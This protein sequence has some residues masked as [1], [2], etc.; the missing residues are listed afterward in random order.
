MTTVDDIGQ[1]HWTD[2]TVGTWDANA[3]YG[4]SAAAKDERSRRRL[5]V[6]ELL[7]LRRTTTQ[8][9]QAVIAAGFD[10]PSRSTI[11]NDVAA[12]RAQ[13]ARNA[14]AFYG[15]MVEAETA[16]LDDLENLLWSKL[17]GGAEIDGSILNGMLRLMERRAKLHGLDK[18]TRVETTVQVTEAAQQLRRRLDDLL[19]ITPGPLA[20]DVASTVLLPS[21]LPPTERDHSA[22]LAAMAE[23]A[24]D[25]EGDTDDEDDDEA[26][27]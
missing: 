12:I 25:D 3:K 14:G 20:I 10:C 26:D 19:G 18:P 27:A 4:H 1:R 7:R 5:L 23:Y 9:H 15:E 13:R 2:G 24:D 16:K 22:L 8:M 6:A 21:Q 11:G 17:F